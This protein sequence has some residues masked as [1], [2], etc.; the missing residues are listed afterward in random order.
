MSVYSVHVTRM[1]RRWGSDDV[2]KWQQKSKHCD[3]LV[4]FL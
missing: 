2:I 4:V 3:A 1:R